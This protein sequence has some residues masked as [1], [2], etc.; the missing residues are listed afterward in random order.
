MTAAYLIN[1]TPTPLLDGK[2]TY[3]LLYKNPPPLSH[4]RVFGSLCYAHNQHHK[5]D[6]FASRSIKGV[7]LGYPH[8]QKGW[9]IYNCDTGNFFTS[10]NVVSCESEFPYAMAAS[11]IP[12]EAP[13]I[14]EVSL[15][16]EELQL[17]LDPVSDPISES[18]P[19]ITPEVPISESP[20][21][22]LDPVPTT[23]SEIEHCPSPESAS[24]TTDSVNINTPT[25]ETETSSTP[26]VS[27]PQ[28][29]TETETEPSPLPP[30]IQEF[31]RGL[32]TKNIPTK[33]HDYVLNTIIPVAASY[34]KTPYSLEF[35]VDCSR[36]SEGHRHFLAAI[37]SMIEPTSYRQAILDKL[38]RDSIQDEYVALED[39]ETWIVVDLPPGKHALSCK[40]VFKFK[41]RADGTLERRKSR[42]VVCGNS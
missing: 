9:H 32:R 24:P 29:E 21:S 26:H 19:D 22:A 40:W 5:G 35:Y 39:N 23:E 28:T 12:I 36:F 33:L 4:L 25:T 27:L 1:R 38:W 3:E 17:P 2:T 37:T 14:T 30:P 10:R 6:K 15:P 18:K 41:F 11:V 31:G 42:L 8:G 16:P 34:T 13:I 20:E 7:F